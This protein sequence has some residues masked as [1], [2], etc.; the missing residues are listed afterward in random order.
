[1]YH[2]V[3]NYHKALNSGTIKREIAHITLEM[4]N[5]LAGEKAD[6]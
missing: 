5:I 4:S 1:M 3:F 6:E 2:K